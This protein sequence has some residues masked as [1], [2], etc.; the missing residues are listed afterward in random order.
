[1][2]RVK[3][4]SYW[5]LIFLALISFYGCKKDGNKSGITPYPDSQC[6]GTYYVNVISE[7]RGGNDTTG[8]QTIYT[9][10]GNENISITEVSPGNLLLTDTL[11]HVQLTYPY[12]SSSGN[13]LFYG[14]GVPGSYLAFSGDSITAFAGTI[15]VDGNSGYLWKGAKVP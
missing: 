6:I 8:P 7:T 3:T 5:L 1:M 4:I 10:I 9:N 11:T 15:S 13:T 2:N 14:G 12:T